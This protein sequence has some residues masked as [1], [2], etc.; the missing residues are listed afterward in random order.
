MADLK[1]F[2][3]KIHGMGGYREENYMSVPDYISCLNEALIK[4]LKTDP[5]TAES[6]TEGILLEALIDHL[7][8]VDKEN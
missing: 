6:K 7:K 2:K 5:P 3:Q 4:V 8:T 1:L